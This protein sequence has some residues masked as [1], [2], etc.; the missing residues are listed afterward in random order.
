MSLDHMRKT[1]EEWIEDIYRKNKDKWSEELGGNKDP[2]NPNVKSPYNFPQCWVPVMR[3]SGISG[4]VV[5]TS[6]N[7]FRFYA[8]IPFSTDY[9]KMTGTAPYFPAN[10]FIMTPENLD[11]CEVKC[12]SSITGNVTHD[13]TTNNKRAMPQAVSL[14]AFSQN[15][16]MTH[17]ANLY[18]S[19]F[20]T[21]SEPKRSNSFSDFTDALDDMEYNNL[22][23]DFAYIPVTFFPTGAT[24]KAAQSFGIVQFTTSSYS[25]VEKI[26]YF[27]GT[28]GTGNGIISM[29]NTYITVGDLN[30][31]TESANLQALTLTSTYIDKI[32]NKLQD[33]ITEYGTSYSQQRRWMIYISSLN[34][35]QYILNNIYPNATL[36]AIT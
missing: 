13:G 12:N 25:E 3:C 19:D 11:K 14:L 6:A 20:V 15:Y 23:A 9:A 33:I 8:G 31:H 28:M 36:E 17:P 22:P 5:I 30:G 18:Q 16:E 21:I 34:L 35:S 4:Q 24:Y 1:I 2:D 7:V 26:Y 10:N 27:D 29:P 32:K